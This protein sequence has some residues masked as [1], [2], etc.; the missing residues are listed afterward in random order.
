V[1]AATHEDGSFADRAF[2]AATDAYLATAGSWERAVQSALAT[3]LDFLASEPQQIESC[4]AALNA[5][6]AQGRR[7]AMIE[8][9]A[10]LLRPDDSLAPDPPA[11]VVSEAIGNAVFGL[12]EAQLREHGPDTLPEALPMATLIALAPF[13]GPEQAERLATTAAYGNS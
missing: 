8:R 13:V 4:M 9:F 6:A 11:R 2:S 12:I 3:L 10:E 7:E 1:T 5:P